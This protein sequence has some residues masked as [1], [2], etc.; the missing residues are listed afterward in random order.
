MIKLMQ[1]KR[2][3]NKITCKAL[4]EDCEIYTPL[5]YDIPS[6]T[7]DDYSLPEG[8]EWC[9]IHIHHAKRFF[10]SILKNGEDLPESRTIMWC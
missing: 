7:F 4:I 3:E 8:Y 10:S 2:E 1:I 6:M 5:S 9:D